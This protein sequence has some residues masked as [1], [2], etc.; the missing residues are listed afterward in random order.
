[1]EV[2]FRLNLAIKKNTLTATGVD[3]S[4]LN[5]LRVPIRVSG[6]LSSLNYQIDARSVME[7]PR[8]REATRKLEQ[9][10]HEKFGIDVE[11]ILDQLF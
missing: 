9:K 5:R 7:D 6:T 8:V 4:R 1:M 2:S 11:G 3:I 10:I